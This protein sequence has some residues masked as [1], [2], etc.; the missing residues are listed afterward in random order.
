MKAECGTTPAPAERQDVKL[1]F[2]LTSLCNFSCPYC[3]REENEEPGFL[4][5]RIVEK[6]LEE[7]RQYQSVNYVA[8]TGGE[9]TLHPEFPALL[10]LVARYGHR[11]GFVT[12]GWQ[13][14]TKTLAQV[15][16]YR[17]HLARVTFSMD[18][19]AE[20]THDTL[21]GRKGSYR[22]LMQAI[23]VCHTLGIGVHVNMVVTRANRDE[24]KAMA[25]L[26]GRLGCDALAYGHCQPTPHSVT[27][28]L[29]LSPAERLQVEHEIAELQRLYRMPILLAGDHYNPSRFHQ[30]SQMQMRE[31][32]IDHRGRLTAC[33]M[34][35][36]FRGGTPDTDVIADLHEVSFY[37][38]HR[39]LVSQIA[40]VNLE[41][42]ERLVTR[43][44]KEKDYFICTHCL[45][46][47]GKVPRVAARS[48]LPVLA[49]L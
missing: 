10:A 49:H 24:L 6:V 45:E 15:K 34:L 18:G 23:T 30:C 13:F 28:G 17:E 40:R 29:A 22:R 31:F 7:T 25:L 41:K 9:P 35:S 33:C 8:F 27:S 39:R 11:F 21:R 32:N 20:E 38:A 42:I 5:V 37:E 26:A 4:P 16:P 12:N 2:E 14:T 43:E 1:I 19:A 3:I 36:G 48:P 47:Y 44:P 46:H